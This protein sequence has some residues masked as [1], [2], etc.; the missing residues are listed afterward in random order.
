MFF[1]GIGTIFTLENSA[2]E[3]DMICSIFIVEKDIKIKY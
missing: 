3:I 2:Y 1:G